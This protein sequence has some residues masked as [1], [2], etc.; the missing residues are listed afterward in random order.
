M[1]KKE[2]CTKEKRNKGKFFFQCVIELFFCYVWM[3]KKKEDLLSN[4][5]HRSSFSLSRFLKVQ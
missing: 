1:S 5:T 2:E 3:S 4:V